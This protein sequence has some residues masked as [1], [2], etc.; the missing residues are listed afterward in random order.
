MVSFPSISFNFHI[1]KKNLLNTTLLL[2]SFLVQLLLYH[3]SLLQLELFGKVSPTVKQHE[4]KGAEQLGRKDEHL[5][6]KEE[7]M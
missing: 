5:E 4:G 7:D 2:P 6:G 3:P 1:F